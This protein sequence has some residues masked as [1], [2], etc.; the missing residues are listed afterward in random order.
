[1]S[2]TISVRRAGQCD[3]V[4]TAFEVALSVLVVAAFSILTGCGTAGANTQSPAPTQP[5]YPFGSSRP[6]Y[7]V[8]ANE[9]IASSPGAGYAARRF[10]RFSARDFQSQRRRN[11][12]LTRNGSC[13]R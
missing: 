2:V 3:R 12:D 7:V 1:M 10:E 8:A 5:S 9:P 6:D 4:R 13:V 11:C